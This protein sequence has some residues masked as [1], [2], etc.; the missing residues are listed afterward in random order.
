MMTHNPVTLILPK[1]INGM[2]DIKLMWG[3]IDSG[4]DK[5]AINRAALPLRC[6][7]TE[8]SA[9]NFLGFGCTATINEKVT[10]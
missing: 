8:I 10:L 9:E 1:R 3:L 5:T 7:I 6:P 2:S 4:S